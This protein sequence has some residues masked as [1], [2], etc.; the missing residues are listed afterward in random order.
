[1]TV[2]EGPN[3][4]LDQFFVRLGD[5]TATQAWRNA[6]EASIANNLGNW[7]SWTS[8]FELWKARVEGS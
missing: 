4:Y 2:Q 8:L 7:V 6:L 3:Y 5:D 1:M